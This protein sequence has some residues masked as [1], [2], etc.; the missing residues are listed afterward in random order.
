MAEPYPVRVFQALM[1]VGA[2]LTGTRPGWGGPYLPAALT[3]FEGSRPA[4]ANIP[5]PALAFEEIGGESKIEGS[6]GGMVSVRHRMEV[7]VT[8]YAAAT[9]GI[10]GEV[11]RLRLWDDFMTAFY[12][13][14]K[15]YTGGVELISSFDVGPRETAIRGAAPRSEFEQRLTLHFFES[16]T[17]QAT[18]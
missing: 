6:V 14:D 10:G 5:V 1:A 8:G 9:S 13:S 15:L 7:R 18:P 11:W 2:S 3:V 4:D 17:L 16:K 12:A